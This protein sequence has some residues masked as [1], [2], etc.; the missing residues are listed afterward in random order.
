MPDRFN[1]PDIKA[2]SAAA[3]D[4]IERMLPAAA[5]GAV[6]IRAAGG[7]NRAA[8]APMQFITDH[9]LPLSAMLG[10]AALEL[11]ERP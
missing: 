10:E 6:R 8:M 4:W 2:R 7:D 3:L 9:M 5:N 1:D 11:S